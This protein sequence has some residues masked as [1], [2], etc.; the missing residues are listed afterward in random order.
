MKKL[1]QWS[2]LSA[3]ALNGGLQQP[4]S[5]RNPEDDGKFSHKI[6]KLKEDDGTRVLVL[7][8]EVE[9]LRINVRI[10]DDKKDESKKKVLLIEEIPCEKQMFVA[11]K[12]NNKPCDRKKA[13]E[14]EN[15]DCYLR[16][17]DELRQE[18]QVNDN[19]ECEP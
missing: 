9:N 14:D 7:K 15:S 17:I 8:S 13:N 4:S 5:Q 6:F 11:A 1:A 2:D 16:E 18:E 12:D 3:V 10:V 19:T